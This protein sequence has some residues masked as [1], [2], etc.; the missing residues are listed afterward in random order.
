M[1]GLSSSSRLRAAA[2]NYHPPQDICPPLLSSPSGPRT[3]LSSG[4]AL[5]GDWAAG[6]AAPATGRYVPSCRSHLMPPGE[7][8]RELAARPQPW[9]GLAED[10]P[11]EQAPT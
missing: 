10:L 5:L 6:L 2:P 11:A 4:Q 9:P 3:Q 1:T 8:V 7:G